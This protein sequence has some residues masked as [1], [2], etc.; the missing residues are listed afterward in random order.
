MST[1][2]DKEKPRP[3]LLQVDAY[4]MER[5]QIVQI[6]REVADKIEGASP[7]DPTQPQDDDFR[8]GMRLQIASPEYLEAFPPQK[9]EIDIPGFQMPPGVKPS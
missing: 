4:T 8:N 9:P 5:S 7:D 3:M 1:E 6:L 2:T